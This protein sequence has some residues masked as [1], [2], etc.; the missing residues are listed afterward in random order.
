MKQVI[1]IHIPRTAGN[2][3]K[4]YAR[5]RSF[6][7]QFKRRVNSRPF[8]ESIMFTCLGHNTA[9]VLERYHKMNRRWFEKCYRFAFVRNS[10]DRMVSVYE[11]YRTFR[12][13]RNMDIMSNRFLVS[14]KSF[15]D[16]VLS[17]KWMPSI[18]SCITIT[19]P[20]FQLAHPQT[21]WLKDGIDF[22]GRYENLDVDWRRLCE[23]TGMKFVPLRRFGEVPHRDY[24]SY[25][26]DDLAEIVGDFYL[27]E[28]ERFGFCFDSGVRRIDD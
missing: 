28:I 18:N 17:R 21:V 6:S 19:R 3:I 12:L 10:W 8:D 5:K 22:V 2:S 24:R 1:H 7:I 16:A 13:R 15:I 27:E 9:K 11:Y 26:N 23:E 14:F 20:Y 25:Y 4:R